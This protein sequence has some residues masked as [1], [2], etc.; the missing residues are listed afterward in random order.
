MG[1]S[2]SDENENE[3]GKAEP[4]QGIGTV[5]DM[6]EAMAK[7]R[8]CCFL[9]FY[10]ASKQLLPF[11]RATVLCEEC[12]IEWLIERIG[13]M[14]LQLFPIATRPRVALVRAH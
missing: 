12:R 7:D 10:H 14:G 9:V 1:A 4:S 5:E 2:M 13:E 3:N 8:G 11:Q 6:Q